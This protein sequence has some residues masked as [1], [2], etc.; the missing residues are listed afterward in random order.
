MRIKII[1]FSKNLRNLRE[2]KKITQEELADELGVSRQAII[3]LERGK[4]IPSLPLA[5]NFARLFEISL[6]NMFGFKKEFQQGKEVNQ[7]ARDLMPWS[8][9]RE[10]SSL[11][12]AIDRL[13]EESWPATKQ[14]GISIPTINVYEKGSKVIVMADVPGVKEE[15]LS[16]EVGVDSL[17]LQG[18][19]KIEEEIKEKNYYR[20]E[21]S[22]GSFSRTIPLPAFV[23]KDKAEAE[24]K[25]GTLT[26]IL[27]KKAKVKPKVTK[28]KVKKR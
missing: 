10:V 7:M 19:R 25:D 18:E 11:H 13:F 4:S 24:L 21:S 14:K 2:Q 22:Y 1:K 5:L 9:M 17:T 26:I 28:V 6:E 27:P 15:D 20:K 12:E 8:P 3:S 16:I 23:N